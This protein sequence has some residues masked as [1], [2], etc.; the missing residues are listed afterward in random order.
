MADAWLIVPD[1]TLILLGVMF[2]RW[3]GWGGEFW[4]GLEKLVYFVLFPALL[5]SSIARASFDPHAVRFFLV[6][7]SATLC[8]ITLGYA[9]KPLVHV[10]RQSFASGVQFAFRLNSFLALA[11]AARLGG[12]GGTALL[13]LL[14]GL[15]VPIC[16]LFSVWGLARSRDLRLARE[17]GR[18]PL[19]LATVGGLLFNCTGWSLPEPVGITLGRLGQA[20]APLGLIAVG[21]GLRMIG[22][23]EA[24]GLSAWFIAVKLLLVPA[25]ALSLARVLGLTTL[26]TQIAVLFA[27]LPSASS[28]YILATRMGGNGPLV[29][30]IVSTST[31][32][33]L[34]TLPLW[35]QQAH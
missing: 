27:A 7:V 15:A 18:N 26:Q 4:R 19:I 22:M 1:F 21:A 17:L 31:L 2:H 11:P 16:N 6:G 33:S 14:L 30:F 25:I 23:R 3:A 5:F 24:P 35:L 32:A 34:L 10:D 9:A 12:E 29:A 8:G 20:S 13:S 28:S